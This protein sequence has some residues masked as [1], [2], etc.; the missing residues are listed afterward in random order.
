MNQDPGGR[1]KL[2]YPIEAVPRARSLRNRTAVGSRCSCRKNTCLLLRRGTRLPYR[3]TY[4]QTFGRR[5]PSRCPAGSPGPRPKCGYTYSRFPDPFHFP[6]LR[7]LPTPRTPFSRRR[8][9]VGGW[10]EWGCGVGRGGWRG[11]TRAPR[12]CLGTVYG[13]GG[14]RRPPS[15]CE[16]ARG[17]TGATACAVY[18]VRVCARVVGGAPLEFGSALRTHT[19]PERTLHCHPLEA[20]AATAP[21]AHVVALAESLV[22]LRRTGIQSRVRPRPN[23]KN[24]KRR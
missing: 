22:A 9:V 1:R 12:S 2:K 6:P 3:Q 16:A 20:A 7:P 5:T 11:Q 10:V 14:W 24:Q 18:R 8:C 17:S 19:W 15:P 13:G 4:R 23:T 21:A